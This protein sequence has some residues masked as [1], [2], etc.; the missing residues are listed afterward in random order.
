MKIKIKS[1]GDECS[2][3]YNK[4]IPKLD[5]N[6]TCLTVICFDYAHKKNEGYYLQL[7]LKECK[8]IEEKVIR[9]IHDNLSNFFYSS[10]QFD[11]KKFFLWWMRK[12]ISAL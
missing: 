12:N 8:Y 9:H 5:S 6:H 1:H 10:D 7:L 3:F 11:E 4:K 2:G